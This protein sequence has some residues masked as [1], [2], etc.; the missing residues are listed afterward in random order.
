MTFGM[1]LL[2]T[3]EDLG[4][5]RDIAFLAYASAT[6]QNDYFSF[7]KEY[8]QYLL[9]EERKPMK[10]AVFLYMQW[11]ALDFEQAKEMV[12]TATR[13]HEAEFLA[14]KKSFL[15]SDPPPSD[16]LRL[17]F[18]GVTQMVVGNLVW[19]TTCPRYDLSRR[20]DINADVERRFLGGPAPSVEEVQEACKERSARKHD[21]GMMITDQDGGIVSVGV[22]TEQSN[23]T[24]SKDAIDAK[25]LS[26][27]S[28]AAPVSGPTWKEI[29]TTPIPHDTLNAD[30]TQQPYD[31]CASSPSKNI[32]GALI[33][34]LQ[35]W[36]Q[37]PPSI[38]TRIDDITNQ[39]H[40]A[41]LLLDDIQ[42]SSRLRRGRPAAHTIYGVPA[43]INSANAAI[44][45]AA[46]HVRLLPSPPLDT[47]ATLLHRLFTGQ[48][49][50]LHWSRHATCPSMPAY[51][52]MIDA[53]TGA[54]FQILAELMLAH[55]T[56]TTTT[57]TIAAL[58][59]RLERLMMLVGRLF[60]IRDDYQ[61]LRD[62]DAARRGPCHDLDEGAFS[63][64]LV[65][66]CH[67]AA[68]SDAGAVDALRNLLA[69]RKDWG[70]LS[71]EMKTVAL[72]Q[73][74]ACGAFARAR[75]TCRVLGEEIE[76]QI[77]ILEEQM[78]CENCGLRLLVEKLVVREV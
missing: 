55:A 17:Y 31:W 16:K 6:L 14:R 60:Q 65:D 1:G 9:S 45:A 70:T 61:N 12:K 40:N 44:F 77:A 38:A 7:D 8:Q 20:Y 33:A 36:L 67:N 53:K 78:G 29:V 54:L 3:E 62:D 71:E 58:Q 19:S 75:E 72:E 13:Q 32:R 56:T 35:T 24:D 48:A 66:A 50:D 43:T 39:L 30:L 10:N 47:F 21:S 49:H 25:T 41:S 5:T 68:G 26:R 46:E 2:M 4:K 34:A 59:P 64:P 42:D 27:P 69:S 11:Q 37:V 57:T 18:E 51:L 63:F 73:L 15:E 22:V 52:S 76:G 23:P 74:E 28:T